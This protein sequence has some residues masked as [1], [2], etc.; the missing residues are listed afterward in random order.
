MIYEKN[1]NHLQLYN[2]DRFKKTE[3]KNISLTNRKGNGRGM[4]TG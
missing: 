1:V 4:P 2:L 3:N